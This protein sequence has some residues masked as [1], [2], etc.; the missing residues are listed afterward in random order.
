MAA[1]NAISLQ[2][3]DFDRLRKENEGLRKEL[4][5]LRE[6]ISSERH[7]HEQLLK[8]FQAC[9]SEDSLKLQEE[10]KTTSRLAEENDDLRFEL[11]TLRES[12]AASKLSDGAEGSR[13]LSEL[14]NLGKRLG[15]LHNDLIS[16]PSLKSLHGKHAVKL[17]EVGILSRSWS[18]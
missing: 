10:K 5:N 16:N 13:L 18:Y 8:S 11:K 6:E 3:S 4:S 12:A 2:M 9:H 1:K 15:S 17:G 7:T 14:C